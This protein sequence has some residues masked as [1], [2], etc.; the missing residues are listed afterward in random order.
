MRIQK[1]IFLML[2]AGFMI[3]KVAAVPVLAAD[4]T[5][6]VEARWNNVGTAALTI[7]FDGNNMGYFA[8][9]VNPYASCTGI[10]GQMRLLD[11]NGN[12][13]AS[14]AIYDDVSPYAVERTYQCQEGKT[15]TLTFQGYAYG[16][17]TTQFDDIE[18]SVSDTCD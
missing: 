14:W 4:V 11:E 18:L 16:N 6:S 9:S 1:K 2:L 10:S 8:I 7:G 5:K 12:L 15:Y 17:G 3:F 13:L